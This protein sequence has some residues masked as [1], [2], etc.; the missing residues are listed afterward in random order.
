VTWTAPPNTTLRGAGN[1]SIVG[2]GDATILID[3]V[4]KQ[5]YDTGMLNISVNSSGTFR[6]MGLTFRS[7]ANAYAATQ[8]GVLRIYGDNGAHFRVDH[9]HFDR[10]NAK[11]IL[12]GGGNLYGVIDHSLCDMATGVCTESMADAW[13]GKQ[14]GDGSWSDATT[15]GSE[16][17]IFVE[18]NVVNGNG[19]GGLNDSYLGSRFVLRY[20]TINRA[21]TQTHPTA[22]RGRGT[23]AWEIYGNTFTAPDTSAEFNAF[24]MSSGTGVIWGNSSSGYKN[25]VTMHNSRS[26]TTYNNAAPPNGWGYCGTAVTGVTSPWDQNANTVNGYACLDQPGSGPGDL[27]SG[28][29]PNAVNTA[30]GTIGWPHQPREPVYEWS[31][32]WA[33]V[34]NEGGSL[35]SVYYDV[36][37]PNRDYYLYTSSFN[38]TSGTG[39]GTLSGRPPTCTPGV[40]Y[41]ATDG[42]GNWN[43][44]NGSSNDGALYKCTATN[45]WTLYYTPYSYPH[46]LTRGAIQTSPPAAPTSLSII[47]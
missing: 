16:R 37:Q 3:D 29:F 12:T 14:H 9:V 43:T 13:G 11:G 19:V 39:V 28:E 34:L 44:S 24:F 8:I 42:G 33:R 6:L 47:K 17:F 31:N 40:A 23:R 10:P 15:L 5:S 18:D 4:N 36:F 25:F 2:G 27:L 45:T 41:W 46:P 20:N 7:S 26:G 35:W 32:N 30:T 38:G 1:E 21:A 22:N